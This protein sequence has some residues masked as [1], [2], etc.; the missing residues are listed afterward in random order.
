M[1]KRGNQKT[2]YLKAE[3]DWTDNEIDG[4]TSGAKTKV[5]PGSEEN[6]I[7]NPTLVL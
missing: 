2:C 4:I 1:T 7:F 6:S 5:C 3:K